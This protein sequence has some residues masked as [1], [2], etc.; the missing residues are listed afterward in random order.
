MNFSA[1]IL[2]GGKSARMGR[3][4]AF[5]DIA[6]ET[7]L[8]RQLALAR[9]TGAEQ[10]FISGRADVDYSAYHCQV[11]TDKYADC[12][13]LAGIDRALGAVSTSLL[14]VLAVDLPNMNAGF[15]RK[16]LAYCGENAGA[17][18]RGAG[19]IEPLAAFYP[20]ATKGLAETLLLASNNAVKVFAGQCVESGFAQFIE[21]SAAERNLF[22]NWNSPGDI[23][24]LV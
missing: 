17:I 19:R 16:C 20:R 14:L 1:V 8:A 3:D 7:L 9:E 18:P 10:I 23:G 24:A 6:G 13:P 15:L 4:K 5:L 21:C 2:A 22:A 11:L 12:G